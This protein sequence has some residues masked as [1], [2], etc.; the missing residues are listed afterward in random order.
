MTEKPDWEVFSHEFSCEQTA[1]RWVSESNEEKFFYEFKE[2]E[3]KT[4]KKHEK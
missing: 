3:Q 2:T 1:S 4:K